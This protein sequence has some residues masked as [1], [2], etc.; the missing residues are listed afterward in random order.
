MK[1]RSNESFLRHTGELALCFAAGAAIVT[2]C[3]TVVEEPLEDTTS[4]PTGGDL[5]ET[6]ESSGSGGSGT[7]GPTATGPGNT[8]TIN[9]SNNNTT[10]GGNNNTSG[11]NNNTSGGNGNGNTASTTGN[12][13]LGGTSAGNNNTT[14]GGNQANT[15]GGNTTS[16]S[17]TTGSRTTTTGGGNTG[18]RTT[19]TG[20]G[21]GA[22]GASS[23]TSPFGGFTA[24]AATTGGA[25]CEADPWIPMKTTLDENGNAYTAGDLVDYMG[26]V[27]SVDQDQ[28]YGHESCPPDGSGPE[29]CS[30]Q[31]S[32]TPVDDC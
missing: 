25:S 32:F 15:T 6:G 30:T 22:G 14:G 2:A 7:D 28:N 3:A 23:T 31:Y 16:G 21:N 18:G 19:T 11:G 12:N 13:P 29:W 8:T 9:T 26:V 27:Y 5:D 4:G 24:T 17:S 1:P 20:F 10:S